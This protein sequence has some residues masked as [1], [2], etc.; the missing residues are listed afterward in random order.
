[1]FESFFG[2]FII[3]VMRVC[4]VTIGTFR[5]ILVVHGKKYHAAIAGF[6]EVLIWIFAMRYIVQNMDQTINLFAYAFGFAAGNILG[7]KLEEKVA[8]GYV[9]INIISRYATD[10]IADTLRL[11]RFAVTLLPGEGGAGGVTV[12][13]IIIRRKDMKNVMKIVDEI[14]T[15]AFI[16]I[17]HSRPYR[18]HIHGARK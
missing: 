3:M 10:K 6:F 17:Q 14:D 12:L 2:A 7:V 1:M 18:G 15:K 8:L 4:D 13:V 16:T 11:S 9:Q 5:T